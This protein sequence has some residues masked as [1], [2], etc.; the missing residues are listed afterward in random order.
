MMAAPV[1]QPSV[2]VQFEQSNSPLADLLIAADNP[3]VI[4]T[5][6]LWGATHT[7]GN[8]DY[9]RLEQCQAIRAFLPRSSLSPDA[10]SKAIW[11]VTSVLQCALSAAA[12]TRI[13]SELADSG[14]GDSCDAIATL[15]EF[16]QVLTS[17]VVDEPDKLIIHPFD[18][19]QSAESFDTPGV[20]GR[21]AVAAVAAV[22]A[23][24]ATSSRAAQA[25]APG[26]AAMAAVPAAPGTSG[27][28][29]LR[30]LSLVSLSDLQTGGLLP[31]AVFCRLVGM[32]GRCLLRADRLR[33][34]GPVRASANQLRGGMCARFNIGAN[35][36]GSLA[37][38]LAN[39]VATI[40]LPVAL[41]ARGVDM[42]EMAIE[43][44]D[45]IVYAGADAA[46]KQSVEMSR[47]GFV[48]PT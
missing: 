33:E 17:L 16:H 30:F 22:V 27:P 28:P 34:T 2:D 32:L 39:Y 4:S 15:K 19:L 26:R 18:L 10:P 41:L 3:F 40:E 12:W 24:R 46:G 1:V 14:L 44:R 47:F 29:S 38:N 37:F 11:A 25:A 48:S 43:G 42:R 9:V 8:I 7:L 21:A 6:F 36:D 23:R 20:P 31:L 45:S 13:L 5:P 35:D